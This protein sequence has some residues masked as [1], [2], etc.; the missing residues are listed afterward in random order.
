V[1]SNQAEEILNNTPGWSWG[2][3][4]KKWYERYEELITF[5]EKHNKMPS[6]YAGDPEGSLGTWYRV[7]RTRYKKD[8]LLPELRIKMEAIP[9]FFS[10]S[11]DKWKA[12]FQEAKEYIE[13]NGSFPPRDFRTKDG[14][15]LFAW[16]RAQCRKR[17]IGELKE[18]K[19]ELLDGI[20]GL[21]EADERTR[22]WIAYFSLT[23]ACVVRQYDG[24]PSL[25]FF[26]DRPRYDWLLE[27][28]KA[29]QAGTLQEY[30]VK[31]LDKT[32]G[33]GWRSWDLPKIEQM[34]R[35]PFE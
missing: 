15:C 34:R 17:N 10:T 35:E 19:R 8:K 23:A 33:K 3:R 1:V 6:P 20:K 9:G 30:Y 11:V 13:T 32:L 26:D 5:V 27:Q 2:V 31:K 18:Y 14:L 12:I 24:K 4:R 16:I 7:Q 29:R 21:K 25:T 22:K 28:Q